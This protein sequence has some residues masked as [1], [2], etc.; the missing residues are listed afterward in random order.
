MYS[1]N[2]ILDSYL[3]LCHSRKRSIGVERKDV[4]H[5]KVK[6]KTKWKYQVRVD[7]VIHHSFLKKQ[8]IHTHMH[9]WYA[10]LYE[11]KRH[12]DLHLYA[13]QTHYVHI[14]LCV[15]EGMWYVCACAQERYDTHACTH[16]CDRTIWGTHVFAY[17]LKTWCIY[18][19]L[20]TRHM[21]HIHVCMYKG[22]STW[23]THVCVHV[24]DTTDV[25]VCLCAD[26]RY[27]IYR[28]VDV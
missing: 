14:C 3:K 6:N 24:K 27:V 19:C 7:Q 23:C 11:H 18:L 1:H 10:C 17:V 15:Y 22:R 5:T 26:R 20:Y 2:V 4:H 8:Q 28:Y 25:R 16:T 12:I 13:Y 9:T 21:I